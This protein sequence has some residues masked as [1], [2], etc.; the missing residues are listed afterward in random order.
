[1]VEIRKITSA[2]GELFDRLAELYIQ[3]F[4]LE[5]RRTTEEL[6]AM[7]GKREEMT[8]SAIYESG[9]PAGLMVYWLFSDFL[10]LEHLA[11]FPEMRN[12]QIGKQVLE[13]LA[14]AF[15]GAR[16]L[17]VEPESDE[18]TGRRIGYYRRNGYEVLEKEYLQ[19]AY[20][21]GSGA[22]LP[23]WIMGNREEIPSGKLP[24]YIRTIRREVYGAEERNEEATKR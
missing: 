20:R 16:I 1:M 3:A 23:L 18:L 5:E 11:V 6:K 19:P 15:P 17:E 12:L 4:P 21:K 10:Y 24:E 7:V 13:Y 14:T 2:S 9:R 8:F 22:P